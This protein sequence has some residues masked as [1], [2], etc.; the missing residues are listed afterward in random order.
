MRRVRDGDLDPG[1]DRG[2]EAG[3]G[4]ELPKE[5]LFDL[6]VA[7]VAGEFELPTE[8][9]GE[10]RGR[11]HRVGSHRTDRPGPVKMEAL[12]QLNGFLCQF[13]EWDRSST[14]NSPRWIAEMV[15]YLQGVAMSGRCPRLTQVLAEG[16]AP[17]APDAVFDRLL[18]RIL[19]AI[20]ET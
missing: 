3:G 14:G 8:P 18:Q 19:T 5:H 15:S 20:C 11:S 6:M 10:W 7:Q 16:S 13:A 1:A 9:S 17:S 4:A 2:L 12:S